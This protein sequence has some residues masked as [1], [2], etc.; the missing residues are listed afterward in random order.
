MT[1]PECVQLYLRSVLAV[2]AEKGGGSE[3]L[4]PR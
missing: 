4:Q 3:D 2:G 1:N